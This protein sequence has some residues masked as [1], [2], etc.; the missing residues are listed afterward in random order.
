M[1]DLLSSGDPSGITWSH[2]G[3]ASAVVLLYIALGVHLAFRID[4]E[5]RRRK[6]GQT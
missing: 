3:I 5:R 2:V 1:K 4:R 6:A